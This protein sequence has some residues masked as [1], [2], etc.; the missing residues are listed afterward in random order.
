VAAQI[1]HGAMKSQVR[2]VVVRRRGRP[3]LGN[4]RLE[5]VLPEAVFDKL[6]EE[7][8]RSGTYRTR[9][10]A[11]VLCEWAGTQAPDCRSIRSY[12]E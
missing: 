4:Y 8:S 6:V 9:I 1:G 10:A 3:K 12:M 2:V 11:N 5:C 7:E